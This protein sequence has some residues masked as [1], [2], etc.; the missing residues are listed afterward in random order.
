MWKKW[1]RII[2]KRGFLK[3][4]L[5]RICKTVKNKKHID[6][7]FIK[8]KPLQS[9]QIIVSI[10]AFENYRQWAQCIVLS[11]CKVDIFSN[12]EQNHGEA[13]MREIPGNT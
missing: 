13:K 4:T 5:R 7:L 11:S 10:L 1:S 2:H 3:L 6:E 12:K 9:N 8:W